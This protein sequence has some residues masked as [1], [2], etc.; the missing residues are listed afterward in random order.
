VRS[1]DV[2]I[3]ERNATTGALGERV[4]IAG[5]RNTAFVVA[6]RYRD[7]GSLL[8]VSSDSEWL[9]M[10]SEGCGGTV[11][12]E[13]GHDVGLF[14]HAGD[15]VRVVQLESGAFGADAG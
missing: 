5:Y 3:L 4:F 15:H 8:L 13:G 7:L 14:P 2:V 1:R 9:A 12:A 10:R 6:S 11:P